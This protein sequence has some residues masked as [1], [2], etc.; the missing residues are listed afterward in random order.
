MIMIYIPIMDII[1][2][3]ILETDLLEFFL[4]FIDSIFTYFF[5]KIVLYDLTLYWLI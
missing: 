3:Y 1:A 4:Q 2:S 5:E